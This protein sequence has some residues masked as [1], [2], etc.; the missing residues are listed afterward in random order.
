M[1][2]QVLLIWSFVHLGNPCLVLITFISRNRYTTIGIG[3]SAEAGG[4]FNWLLKRRTWDE[5]DE[6]PCNGV[7]A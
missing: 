3:V 5:Q 4:W 6:Q 7:M 1:V 2:V